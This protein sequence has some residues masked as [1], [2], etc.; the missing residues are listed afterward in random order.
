MMTYLLSRDHVL[1][2]VHSTALKE[3]FAHHKKLTD[4]LEN[5]QWSAH[6]NLGVNIPSFIMHASCLCES[7]L[8]GS[9]TENL[10]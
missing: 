6:R 4:L 2:D 7:L 9:V 3:Q 5:G 1:S 10:F 8:L